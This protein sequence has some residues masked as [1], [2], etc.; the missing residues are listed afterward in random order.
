MSGV[1]GQVA[2]FVGILLEVV[3]LELVTLHVAADRARRVG[4]IDAALP[5]RRASSF[6]AASSAVVLQ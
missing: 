2:R 1:A 5:R 4:R 6:T 3:Q